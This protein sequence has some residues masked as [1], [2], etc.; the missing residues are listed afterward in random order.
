MGKLEDR[1]AIVTG[2]S[3]GIGRAIALTF[4]QEGA[5]VVVNYHE[6]KDKADEVV[7]KI[8]KIGNKALSVKSDVADLKSVEDMIETAIEQFGKIDILV[9]NAGILLRSDL[10]SFNEEDLNIMWDINVKGLLYCTRAVAPYMISNNYGK[11]INLSSIAGIGTAAIAT[12]PYAATKAAIIVLTKRFALELGKYQINVNAIAPG[13]IK[14][15]MTINSKNQDTSDKLIKYCEEA[16]MLH[17]LGKP[18][19]IA[20][21]AL[22]MA[23]DD[24]SFMTGQ[25]ITVD[26]GRIDLLTHSI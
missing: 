19:D 8:E 5:R 21:V 23:S 1:V 14:T 4:A 15:D 3:R 25:I 11:I 24:S 16:T 6:K 9:N 20:N 22:F 2:A 13:L 18:Q 10:L 7:K 17:R 26:G 12:T